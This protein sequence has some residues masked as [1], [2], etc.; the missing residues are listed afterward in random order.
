MKDKTISYSAANAL[1]F[2]IFQDEGLMHSITKKGKII[3]RHVQVSP[4]NRCNLSCDF[5]SCSDVEKKQELPARDLGELTQILS[6]CGTKGVTITGGG[7]PTLHHSI[8]GFIYGLYQEGIKAG[9]VTNGI[10]VHSLSRQSLDILTWCRVSFSDDRRFDKY[11]KGSMEYLEG[12][13]ID[14]AFSYVATNPTDIGKITQIVNWAN[15]HDFTHVRVVNDIYNPSETR[16]EAIEGHLKQ[17]G[18]DDSKVIY[19]ARSNFTKGVED[20]NI[21]LLKPV[22]AADGYVYPCCGVQ[23]ALPDIQRCFPESMRMGHYS[24][25]EEIIEKQVPFNGAVCSKCYYD[26]Y[27]TVLR[28]MKADVAHKEFL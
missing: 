10:P 23:Y 4:T 9:L 15:N 12:H 17:A 28:A 21:S 19:Q 5:C 2:K 1:P 7:E 6:R 13:K 3:P 11:F 14:L 24:K 22:I 27:N 20:C 18:I 16:M 25:L 8:N 26:N